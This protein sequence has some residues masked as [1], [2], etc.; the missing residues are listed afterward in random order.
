MTPPSP[1]PGHTLELKVGGGSAVAELV[2]V[3]IV[4][5]ES[6]QNRDF[7]C[8]MTVFT[9]KMTPPPAAVATAAAAGR[10]PR[11]VLAARGEQCWDN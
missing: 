5:L 3:I 6:F 8:I 2:D 4:R 7:T 10:A 11:G 1:P 9:Y